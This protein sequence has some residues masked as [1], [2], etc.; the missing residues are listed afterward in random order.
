MGMKIEHTCPLGSECETAENN[1]IKR[2][3]W[4]TKIAG[5]DP[6]T[7]KEVE[8]FGCAIAWLPTLLIESSQQSHKTT[9]AVETFRNEMVQ[10]NELS[11][12]LLIAT[13]K[14]L[15]N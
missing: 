2:C 10:S 5:T 11:R 13:D 7:G 1:V 4:Y 6:N 15:L 12:E 14:T 9:T 3:S 8:D